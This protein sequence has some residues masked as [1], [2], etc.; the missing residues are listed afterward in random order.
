MSINVVFDFDG[1]IHSYHSPWHGADV[2]PDEPVEGIKEAIEEIRNAGYNVIVVSTRSKTK[3]GRNAIR[4]WLDK[5]GIVVDEIHSEK[6][7]AKVYIDDRAICFEGNANVL[8]DKINSF[9][10]CNKE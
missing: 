7:P 5:Y 2:I 3:H 6:P 9:H 10:P 1:V 4:E 8:L